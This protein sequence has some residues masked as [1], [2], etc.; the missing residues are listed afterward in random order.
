MGGHAEVILSYLAPQGRLILIDRDDQMLKFAQKRL[1]PFKQQTIFGHLSFSKLDSFLRELKID[2]VNGFLFDLG[3]CQ[4]HLDEPQRGFSYLSEGPLDFRM[5]QTQT[6]TGFDVVN[7]YS[8]SDLTRILSEYGEERFSK[9]IAKAIVRQREK[10]KIETTKELAQIVESKV[11]LRHKIKSLSRVFQAIRIEVNNELSELKQGI[12]KAVNLLAPQGRICIIS[13]HS[14]EDRIVKTKFNEFAKGC[15]CP[16]FFPVCSCGAKAILSV[17]TKKP[18]VPDLEE[19]KTN[20]HSRSAKLRVAVKL[21]KLDEKN[22][23]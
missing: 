17:L 13:Y 14:L 11:D 5:D 22:Q 23:N 12:D 8:L 6:K 1:E 19:K 7:N 18:I 21:A 10:K 20:P 15:K 9:S 2:Q 3:L 16:P 4:A